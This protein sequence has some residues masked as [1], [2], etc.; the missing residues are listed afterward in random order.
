[1]F[2]LEGSRYRD[3]ILVNYYVILTLFNVIFDVLI[4]SICGVNNGSESSVFSF[5]YLRCNF[6]WSLL[7]YWCCLSLTSK[8]LWTL[9]WLK[10]IIYEFFYCSKLEPPS[11]DLIKFL[12][13]CSKLPY[14]LYFNVFQW[15]LYLVPLLWRPVKVNTYLLLL[16]S[17]VYRS[18]PHQ[19]LNV[20]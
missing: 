13:N 4:L 16:W 17:Y 2:L 7:F 18:I 10:C 6:L 20:S 19:I 1:M 3:A 15:R 5:R 9:F 8:R 14:L 11:E 12:K